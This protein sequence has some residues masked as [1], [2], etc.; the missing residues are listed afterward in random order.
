[1][2]TA[3]MVAYLVKL[4]LL[5]AVKRVSFSSPPPCRARRRTRCPNLW[6][7]LRFGGK[8]YRL[9]KESRFCILF[10]TQMTPEKLLWGSVEIRCRER[11]S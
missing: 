10:H 3:E 2:L 1:M 5:N 8:C 4:A 7:G 9:C 11:G 6:K